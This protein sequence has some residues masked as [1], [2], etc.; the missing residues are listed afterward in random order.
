MSP[1][2]GS[3]VLNRLR[4]AQT[5][6]AS[7]DDHARFAIGMIALSTAVVPLDVAL[8]HREERVVAAAQSFADRPALVVCGAPRS[9]TTVVAQT[10]GAA[11]DVSYPTNL[12]DMFPRS[13]ITAT[14]LFKAA[15]KSGADATSS[16][17]GRSRGFSARSDALNIWD[18]YLSGSRSSIDRRVHD[19]NGLRGFF[20]A[21]AAEWNRPVVAKNNGAN[22]IA[23]QVAAALP[24]V[25]F[26]CVERDPVYNAQSLLT[27]RRTMHNADDVPYGVHHPDRSSDPYADI[28]NQVAFHRDM[29]RRQAGHIGEDRFCFV[30]YEAFCRNPH[31]TVTRVAATLGIPAN[32]ARVPTLTASNRQRL[33]RDEFRRLEEAVR[34]RVDDP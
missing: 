27:A 10:L 1:V 32:M 11:L 22:V 3:G 21:M 12:M 5:A 26:L 20:G 4:T 13:P 33:D 16:F 14:R 15:P 18:R 31:R 29:N 8:R 30:D 28:A 17:Y 7:G 19:P 25:Y 34:A 24:K 9:G 6:L 2:P 23:D